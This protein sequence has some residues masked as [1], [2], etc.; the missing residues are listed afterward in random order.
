MGTMSVG[1][2]RNRVGLAPHGRYLQRGL[3]PTALLTGQAFRKRDR[4]RWGSEQQDG[5]VGRGDAIG[6]DQG[7]EVDRLA[8]HALL[9][10]RRLGDGQGARAKM[11]AGLWPGQCRVVLRVA[12]LADVD[13]RMRR[14][15]A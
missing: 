14:F 15:A 5:V 12:G 4:V 3:P 9:L 6:H 11:L 1:R 2:N 8:G 10:R 7:V 13:D